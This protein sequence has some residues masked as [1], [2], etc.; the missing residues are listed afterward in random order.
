MPY[1]S[2]EDFALMCL[3]FLLGH[4]LSRIRDYYFGKPK[5]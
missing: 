2:F 3:A 1:Q 4:L 5:E